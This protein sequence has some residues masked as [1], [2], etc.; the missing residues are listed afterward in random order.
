RIIAGPPTP[1]LQLNPKAPA[2]PVRIAEGAMARELRNR[3]AQMTDVVADLERAKQGLAPLG[4]HGGGRVIRQ[5]LADHRRTARTA[6]VA[7][8]VLLGVLASIW[9][10]WPSK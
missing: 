6:A 5:L 9:F 1:I 3:Y 4:P 7:V 10:L 2:N 8:G